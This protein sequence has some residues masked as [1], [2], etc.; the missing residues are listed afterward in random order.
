M[1]QKLKELLFK[2]NYERKELINQNITM[3]SNHQTRNIE[4]E[5]DY[6]IKLAKEENQKLI[7]N[8]IKIKP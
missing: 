3:F 5:Y 7:P 8:F 4:N 6:L 2:T 1:A